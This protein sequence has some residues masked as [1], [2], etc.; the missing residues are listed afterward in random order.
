MMVRSYFVLLAT[1]PS[2]VGPE[3]WLTI[4]ADALQLC[5]MLRYHPLSLTLAASVISN[6]PLTVADYVQEWSKR[7]LDGN[8]ITADRALL[9]SFEISFE[10]LEHTS[11]LSAKLLMLFSF[12]DHRDMWY[13]LC[14]SAT[15]EDY[16]SWLRQIATRKRFKEF[17]DPLRNLLFVEHKVHVRGGGIAYEIHPAIHEFARWKAMERG[18]EAECVRCAVSLV[19]ANVPRSNDEDFLAKVQRLEPHA[20]QCKIYMEQDRGGAGLDLVELKK[21]GDLFRHLGRYDEASKFY[22]GILSLLEEENPPS[23]ELMAGIE[24]NLGLVYHAQRNYDPAIQAYDRSLQK[25]RQIMTMGDSSA[26]M[27]TVYNQGRAL[28][29]LGRLDE[30]L[31]SLQEAAGYFA[32]QTQ[33]DDESGGHLL[34]DEQARIYFRILNDIGEIHLR[35][36]AVDEAEEI[37]KATFDGLKR[38]LHPLHPATFAVRLNMGRVCI[39]QHR[40]ATA[41]KIFRYIIETYMDWWGRRHSETMRAVAELADAHMRHGEMKRLMGDG[42]DAQLASAEQLWSEVLDFHREVY[43]ASSDIAIM[44]SS[45][46]QMLRLLLHEATSEDPYNIYYG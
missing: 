22:R 41:E 33:D 37:F 43:G 2:D 34:Q 32:Q 39:E 30:S 6:Y 9:H 3:H 16:P 4:Y 25:M 35:M 40:F 24:N 42:G 10:E 7:Q 45:K 23:L 5:S 12:L 26:I 18:S 28:L 14:L 27:F 20:D 15:D 11:P 17:Y 29:M 46:L 19:A 36:K 8:A 38:Y 13:D 31:Q 1:P 21:F 44:A